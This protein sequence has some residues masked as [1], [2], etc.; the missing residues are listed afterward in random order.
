VSSRATTTRAGSGIVLVGAATTAKGLVPCVLVCVLLAFIHFLLELLR[1]LL[2]SK[3]QA[4]QTV[5]ELEG[6]KEGT[7]LVV[8]EGV[9]DF[10][11]PDNTTV[12]GLQMWLVEAHG[13]IEEG[14]E[15]VPRRQPS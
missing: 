14:G 8:L 6:V 2:V 7:V 13:M 4:S 9:I 10:L 12:R 11:V 3:R 1:F 15:S 5:L